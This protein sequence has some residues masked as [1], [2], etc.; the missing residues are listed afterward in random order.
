MNKR[1][2][3]KVFSFKHEPKFIIL[4]RIIF[5][6]LEVIE[7]IKTY[8]NNNEK[9]RKEIYKKEIRKPIVEKTTKRTKK[10]NPKPH[11]FFATGFLTG[12]LTLAAV[13]FIIL[14]LMFV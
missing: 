14:V 5:W 6:V 10:F 8:F 7:K 2:A 1:I 4:D 12:F 13:I 3:K 11:L 9:K